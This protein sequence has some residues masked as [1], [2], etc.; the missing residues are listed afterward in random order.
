MY[1]QVNVDFK[2]DIAPNIL[3]VLIEKF[4]KTADI[5]YNFGALLTDLSR[6]FD[7]LH[8]S[9]LVAKLYWYGL[10]TLYFKLIFSSF[11]NRTHRTKINECF[12]NRSKIKYGLP[13][14]SFLGPLL[15]NM[16]STD[17]FYEF[18][19]SDN[20]NYADDIIPCACASDID[21]VISELQITASKLYVLFENNDIKASHEKSHHFLKSQNSKKKLNLLEP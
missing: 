5:G 11:S 15:F 21:I 14:G 12:I 13:Q 1:N 3:L 18:G 8:H 4:R 16:N 17:I 20:E 19:G 9:V 7:C 2:K 10:L 6:A